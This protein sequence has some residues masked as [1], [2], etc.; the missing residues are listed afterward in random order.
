LMFLLFWLADQLYYTSKEVFF[1]RI[2]KAFWNHQH[3]WW[4]SFNNIKKGRFI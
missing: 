1:L 3:C 4:F 2:A